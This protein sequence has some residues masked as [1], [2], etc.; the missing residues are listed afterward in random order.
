MKQSRITKTEEK[1][2][3][4]MITDQI[5]YLHKL[6]LQLKN[7]SLHYRQIASKKLSIY[8]ITTPID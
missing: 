7:T 4:T 8:P 2:I 5:I 6:P 1:I 3:S